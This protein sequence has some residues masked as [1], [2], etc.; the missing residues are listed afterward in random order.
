[1]KNE[2][3]NVYFCFHFDRLPYHHWH[4]NLP[5]N[6]GASGNQ[7]QRFRLRTFSRAILCG[8]VSKLVRRKSSPQSIQK[9]EN[10]TALQNTLQH[11]AR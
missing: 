8:S 10:L 11:F 5:R 6:L 9:R 3:Y 7:Q 2:G 1:M 4:R